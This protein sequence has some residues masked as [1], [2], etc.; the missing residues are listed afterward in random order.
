MKRADAQ[1]AQKFPELRTERLLLRQITPRDRAAIYEIFSDD[2][3]LEH[4]DIDPIREKEEA[5]ELIAFFADRERR[6]IGIRWAIALSKPTIQ[7]GARGTRSKASEPKLIG[8]CG[9][10]R[11][12]RSEARRG[13]VGYDL[14]RSQWGHG[15]VPEAMEA[16]IR[17]G[18]EELHL[19]RIEAYVEPGN[20]RSIRVMEKLGFT[21]EGLLRQF[22][23]YRRAARDQLCFS[24]LAAEWRRSHGSAHEN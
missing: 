4:Y 15:Y 23:F 2:E 16:V 11:F 12:E 5:S 17:Y 8:T 24:L 20:A 3:T 13:V 14:S 10:N 1:A 21:R 9:F 19:N 6:G 22:A 7:V 18:F